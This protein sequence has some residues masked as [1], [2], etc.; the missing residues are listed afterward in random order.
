MTCRI[1]A[2][3]Q[4]R[5]YEAACVLQFDYNLYP[6]IRQTVIV[7][8]YEKDFLINIF[9]QFNIDCSNFVF[10][11]DLEISDK[12]AL[13]E[14]KKHSWYFQQGIKLSLLDNIDSDWFLIHDCDV[15]AA[16]PYQYIKDDKP[17]FRVEDLWNPYQEI[18]ASNVDR[19][20]AYKRK[21]PYSFVT[22][23]M[24]YTKADWL[25]CKQQIESIAGCSWQQAILNKS[26]DETKWFSEYEL[27]GIFKTNISDDYHLSHDCHPTITNWQDFEIANW[28]GVPTVK[29]KARPL[30]FMQENEIQLIVNKFKSRNT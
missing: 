30:K 14:W 26:F 23:I 28:E 7:S 3:G 9:Q 16:A 11:T 22:E 8:P 24:P 15:F 12:F 20:V 18:Y 17:N 1:M 25:L 2:V 5:I 21:I 13:D 10:Y 6:T 29:F 19:L 4:G 27:L